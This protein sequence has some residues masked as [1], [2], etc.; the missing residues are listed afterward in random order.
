MTDSV[1]KCRFFSVQ[2]VMRKVVALKG[3]TEQIFA[4]VIYIHFLFGIDR[5]NIFDK[6]KVTEGDTSFKRVFG[7]ASVGSLNIVHIKLSDSLL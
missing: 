5:E 4:L 7:N 6:I 1:G 3:M 2:N